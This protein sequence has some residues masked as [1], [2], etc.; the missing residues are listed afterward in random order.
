MG[1]GADRV[2]RASEETVGKVSGEIESIRGEIGALVAELDRRRHEAFDLRLQARRHPVALAIV[3]VTLALAVGGLVALAVT[4]RERRRRPSVR[5]RETRRALQRN[6]QK[7]HRVAAEP[8]LPGKIIAA[9]ATA[10]AA[11]LARRLVQ[12]RA[13]PSTGRR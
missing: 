10:T 1:E 8:S 13:A 4:A 12:L 9:A 6:L 2:N 3:A 7:P 11:T 5:A